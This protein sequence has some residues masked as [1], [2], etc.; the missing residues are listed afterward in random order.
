LK[1]RHPFGVEQLTESR[2]RRL[3]KG[4]R[5]MCGKTTGLGVQRSLKRGRIVF[6]VRRHANGNDVRERLG[7]YPEMSVREARAVAVQRIAAIDAG[8]RRAQPEATREAEP[9][10]PNGVS[11]LPSQEGLLKALE[12][13]LVPLLQGAPS[14]Q[15]HLLEEIL[16][17]LQ[18]NQEP[19]N[20][21]TF[22]ELT[23]RLESG[24]FTSLAPSTLRSYR[25][26]LKAELTPTFGSMRLEA[27]TEP[28]LQKWFAGFAGQNEQ[29]GNNCLKLLLTMLRRAERFGWVKAAP[30]PKI[31][32]YKGRERKGIGQRDVGRLAEH[33]E[34]LI[35]TRPTSQVYALVFMLNSG[36]RREACVS[37]KK[38]E[39]D[40]DKRCITKRRKGGKVESI[41]IS[42]WLADFLRSIWPATGEYMFPSHSRTG[43]I[44]AG[45]L[46]RYLKELCTELKVF[47]SDGKTP[48]LHT[49]RHTYA[50]LLAR[51]MPLVDVKELL[52]HSQLSTTMRYAHGDEQQARLGAN[53]LTVTQVKTRR[54]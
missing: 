7:V 49:L 37:L 28:M 20:Q 33:L 8:A 1:I 23:E 30:N 18:P 24:Y 16:L 21:L 2:V 40:L 52:G 26:M 44:S 9:R 50:S 3:H 6:F 38:S 46:L 25:T 54:M 35:A 42:D 51:D 39:V 36:E 41:P 17:R 10:S 11:A 12:A 5:V 48:V 4:E 43:H 13:R 45:Y 19:E 22:T 29:Q 15:T 53:R 34:H 47:T 31:K 14:N 27:I 32:R